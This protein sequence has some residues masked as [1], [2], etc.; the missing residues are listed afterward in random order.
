MIFIISL[1]DVLAS[2]FLMTLIKSLNIKSKFLL[3]EGAFAQ[4]KVWQSASIAVVFFMSPYISLLAM[5]VVMV[6]A[7]CIAVV[8]FLF[9]TLQVEKAFSSHDADI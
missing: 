2:E 8:G 7:V 6:A 4:L 1:C 3:Q 9:L 5:L